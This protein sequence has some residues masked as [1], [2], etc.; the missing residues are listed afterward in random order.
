MDLIAIVLAAG[1]SS[2]MGRDK[3]ALP[4][5]D[6]RPL[7]QWMTES[8]VQSGWR[9][10]VVLGPHNYSAWRERIP[11]A[12]LVL[13]P[14]PELGKTGSIAAAARSLRAPVWKLLLIAVDQPRPP[15]LYQL[16]RQAATERP[17]MIVTPNN[18]GHRGHPVI[19]DGT[20]CEGLLSLNERILGLRGLLNEFR[21]STHLLSCDPSWLQWDCNTPEAYRAALAWFEEHSASHATGQET[22]AVRNPS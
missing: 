13:N 22:F 16:L 1:A 10:I 3:A 5:L 19:I 15:M 11:G 4:W 21:S 14:W 2:R 6:G 17:E 9:P 12:N 20:L 8:L 18:A 7:L